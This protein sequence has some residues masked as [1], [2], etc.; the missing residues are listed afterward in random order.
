[1]SRYNRLC[2]AIRANGQVCK[3]PLPPH[4]HRCFE[5]SK[6]PEDIAYI[7]AQGKA[8]WL[9]QSQRDATADARNHFAHTAFEYGLEDQR[10]HR[11][12]AEWHLRKSE[13]GTD[14][15]PEGAKP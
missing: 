12:F 7:R 8:A 5:H 15:M 4:L 2:G 6:R 14:C 13:E 9:L 1:M 3:K 10:T 11:A